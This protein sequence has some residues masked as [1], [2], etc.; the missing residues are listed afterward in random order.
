MHVCSVE[1]FVSWQS[2]E[3][4]GKERLHAVHDNL[5][6]WQTGRQLMAFEKVEVDYHRGWEWD[7]LLAA[8]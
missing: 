6:R 4:S 3:T 7:E 1:Q 8:N 2:F 5:T